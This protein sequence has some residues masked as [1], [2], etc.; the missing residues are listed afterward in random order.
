[1]V[2]WKDYVQD[3]DKDIV[4]RNDDYK[5]L[6][7]NQKSNGIRVTLTH[8]GEAA[9][10]TGLTC[11]G[12]VLCCKSGVTYHVYGSSTAG[13]GGNN[14]TSNQA[15]II[16]PNDAYLVPGLVVVT[17]MLSSNSGATGTSAEF[18]T[19]LS[20]RMVV[21]KVVSD[22]QREPSSVAVQI[23]NIAQM[24]TQMETAKNAA[25]TAAAFLP[26]TIASEYSTAK[27]YKHGDI[28]I[29]NSLLYY[30]MVNIDVNT[31]FDSE[32]F[33]Q[34]KMEDAV[35]RNSNFAN[36]SYE[37]NIQKTFSQ[38]FNGTYTQN[39][40]RFTFNGTTASET[41]SLL[42]DITDKSRSTVYTYSTKRYA[43][44]SSSRYKTI[45]LIEGHTYRIIT[46]YI[47]GTFATEEGAV[48]TVIAYPYR[49]ADIG[50][51]ST[52][53]SSRKGTALFNSVTNDY[54][55]WFT[56]TSEMY[57]N[58]IY[59]MLNVVRSGAPTFTDYTIDVILEDVTNSMMLYDNIAPVEGSVLVSNR[60]VGDLIMVNGLLY[61]V[62][63]NINAGT[64]L[65]IDTNI[66]RT[67]IAEQLANIRALLN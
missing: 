53:Y 67:S 66:E 9:D 15:W 43:N 20:V 46:K 29:N 50:D 45:N 33:C 37:H 28:V 48:K 32:Y 8:G 36:H 23:E 22:D 42:I 6:N 39:G 41:S 13:I 25:N 24:Y 56:Y 7:R 58:G 27:S 55:T 2:I 5:L 4:V 38:N 11:H 44:A 3:L 16:I 18:A 47:S 63:S 52:A 60:N 19:V 64:T 1:M 34:L 59:F 61:R 30:A 57:P 51:T 49:E 12:Y 31:A 35:V 21:E 54:E 65:K 40:L 17:I 14:G 26:N 62:M 10:L